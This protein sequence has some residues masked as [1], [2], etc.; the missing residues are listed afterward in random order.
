[1]DTKGKL[2]YKFY[3]HHLHLILLVAAIFC[4]AVTRVLGLDIWWHLAVGKYLLQTRSFPAQD[5]FSFTGQAWDNKEWLFGIL[6]F[7]V[8]KA[9][10]VNM[11]TIAKAALFTATFVVLYF[12]CVKRSSNRYLSLGIVLLAALAC[13]IRLAFRPE[14]AT[15]LCIAILLL[16]LD[17]YLRGRRKPLCY[18]P[19]VMILWVNLHPLALLGLVILLIYIVGD[20]ISRILRAQ[21]M[22]SGWRVLGGRE[23]LLLCVIF[24][25]SCVAFSCNPISAQR[26]LSPFELMTKHA[27]FLSSLTET[28]PL[29]ILQFPAFAAVLLLSLFTLVMF[30]TTMEP[31]DTIMLILFGIVSVTMARN[32]PLLAVCAAPILAS[33][34]AGF[35]TQL[36]ALVGTFLARWK[37]AADIAIALLL[38]ALIVW[39][40]LQQD[41]G[42]GYSGLLY[43]EGA[44]KY[45]LEQSPRAGMFNI[46]DWG[47][48][49]IWNLYPRYK[50]F[51]D[52]RGPDVYSPAM[53][54]DY[55]TAEMGRDGW[56]KVLDRY[57][58]NFMLISTGNKLH[59]LIARVNESPDWRLGYWDFQS[60]VF[61]RNIPEHRRMIEAYD[62]KALDAKLPDFKYFVP[63]LEIQIMSELHNYLKAH[64]DSMGGH[65]LLAMSY[66]RS[67]KIDQAIEEFNRVVKYHPSTPRVHYNLGMLYSQRGDA[68]RALAAYEQ[69]LVLDPKFAPAYNNAGRIFYER[70]DLAKAERYFKKAIKA[71]PKYYLAMNNLGLVCMDAG[72]YREAVAEFRKA[73]E[74]DPRYEGAIRNLALAEEMLA[75]PAET[76][77]RLGQIYY[78]Q[79]NLAK[80]EAQFKKAL[81]HNPKYTVAMGNLGVVSLKKGQYEEAIRRFQDVL[82]IAPEDAAARQHLAMA[83]AMLQQ[84][85]APAEGR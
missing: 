56:E 63:Q 22:D 19:L 51:M 11:L 78:S 12:L 14:L 81:E 39:A 72:R 52:G 41:F 16:M 42:L 32:A 26:F 27:A 50:V 47:G 55:E 4:L 57:G 38:A 15:Y 73:I 66:L 74:I 62:Y 45:V 7:L 48:F 76:C 31:A 3:S 60:M 49:L 1:M 46:Y 37:K 67:G 2:E 58:V 53:W 59:D 10:G 71:D 82:R 85:K 30:V 21:A 34:I 29:P 80:A 35:F 8:Q 69:E 54:A 83:E 20:I 17:Q 6:V 25:A 61:V 43:P 77:N 23:F 44:V 18:F 24:L 64:P 68:D 13:R 75:H 40:C 65:N 84:P 36:P 9:G 5:V 33:Q 79:N 28:K 70:G